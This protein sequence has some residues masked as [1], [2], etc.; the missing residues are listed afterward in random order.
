MRFSTNQNKDSLDNRKNV[1]HNRI[2]KIICV[3]LYTH[4]YS[5]MCKSVFLHAYTYASMMEN[6]LYFHTSGGM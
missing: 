2:N 4:D 6:H 3:C 1:V 5:I